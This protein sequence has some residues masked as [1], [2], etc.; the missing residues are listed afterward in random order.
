[1]ERQL[2]L[3]EPT[4]TVWRLD[5][6]TREVGKRGVEQAR[7]AMRE[8]LAHARIEDGEQHPTAA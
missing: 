2:A 6:R 5:E 3:I 1:M 7:Q 8:A 4:T